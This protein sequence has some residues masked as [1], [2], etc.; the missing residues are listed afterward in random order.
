MRTN[1]EDVVGKESSYYH[2]AEDDMEVCAVVDKFPE[3]APNLMYFKFFHSKKN[4][5]YYLEIKQNGV[6][7]PER[8]GFHI[9]NDAM[10]NLKV[11]DSIEKGKPLWKSCSY[12]EEDLYGFGM[13][14]R[15]AWAA[16][17]WTIEDA[18]KI[19][20]GFA[21]KLISYEE[22]T[23]S[24]HMN[25][26]DFM[27]NMYGDE[28][29][30]K[31]FPDAGGLLKDNMLC[32]TSHRVD[33]QVLYDMKK[34]NLKEINVLDD[35]I[36]YA[37]SSHNARVMDIEIYPNKS[38]DEIPD[39]DQY[40]QIRYYIA[41]HFRYYQEINRICKD[42]VESG[43]DFD[44][45]IGFWCKRSSDI[46][47]ENYGFSNGTEK[48]KGLVMNVTRPLTPKSDIRIEIFSRFN[49]IFAD[50]V[51]LLIVSKV[52]SYIIP[53]LFI[54]IGVWNLIERFIRIDFDIHYPRVMRTLGI[55][56]TIIQYVNLF[57]IR[58]LHIIEYL[59]VDSMTCSTK[60]VI[61]EQSTC[62]R[63][64]FI[65][66]LIT[67]HVTHEVVIVHVHRDCLFLI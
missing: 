7:C 5:K 3:V 43:E 8:F 39:T 34:S 11:G 22:E 21:D 42:I 49:N 50:S 17:N 32:A 35:R 33:S 15:V 38:L 29:Y 13:N 10:D 45:D 28:K 64:T 25:D 40:K 1:Y 26:N 57:Q 23:V 63:E 61:F 65:V 41:N 2:T 66:F 9:N 48:V 47:D 51:N 46:L 12:D 67:I 60:H 36:Y 58:L 20:K 27:R 19:R 62:V 52:I 55:I 16:D 6:E 14:A 44:S 53:N 59:T 18:I 37:K 54:L 4:H 31:G 24:V 30:Y 56:D